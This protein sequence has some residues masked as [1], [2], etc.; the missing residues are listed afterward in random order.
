MFKEKYVLS[1]VLWGISF[2]FKLQ[3]IYLLPFYLIYYLCRK[4]EFQE[5]KVFWGIAI[6]SLY[7]CNFFLTNMHER[8][9]YIL[10]IVAILY[11]F[12]TPMG[13]PL[14]VLLNL[15]SVFTYANYLFG[16]QAIPSNIVA[17]EGIF[18]YAAFSFWLFRSV[19][20]GGGKRKQGHW[21]WK[22]KY[23]NT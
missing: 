23:D 22:T 15:A 5:A 19:L 18:L 21:I 6:W 17:F 16:Y 3:A 11:C 1:F 7:T 20:P 13:I 8:Y 14:A 9:A 10:E 12:V 4:P 2:A